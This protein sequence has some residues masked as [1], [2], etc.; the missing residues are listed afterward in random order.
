MHSYGLDSVSHDAGRRSGFSSHQNEN[1][2]DRLLLQQEACERGVRQAR[3]GDF[4]FD[5]RPSERTERASP[6]KT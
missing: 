2:G 6:L 4:R 1:I 5:E 3:K